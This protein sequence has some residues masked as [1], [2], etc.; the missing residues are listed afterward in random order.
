M[1]TGQFAEMDPRI[2]A[3]ADAGD[4]FDMGFIE[5]RTFTGE[6]VHLDGRGWIRCTFVNCD[7]YVVLGLTVVDEC[8]FVDSRRYIGDFAKTVARAV[9]LLDPPAGG[10][11]IGD[12]GA[13]RPRVDPRPN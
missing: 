4:V 10:D 8:R 2:K 1:A 11:V 6:T 3:M 5:D 9:N 12:G 13:E 7:V